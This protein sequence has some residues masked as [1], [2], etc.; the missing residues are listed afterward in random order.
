MVGL[1]GRFRRQPGGLHAAGPQADP[2]PDAPLAEASTTAAKQNLWLIRLAFGLAA[3][4]MAANIGL[5]AAVV[6][7]AREW[8]PFPVFVRMGG[9]D[10]KVIWFEPGNVAGDTREIV[11]EKLLLQFVEA[12]ETIDRQTEQ[13]RWKF[14]KYLMD[15]Q[16]A[17][18]FFR[19]MSFKTNPDSPYKK[20]EDAK[21][22]RA[23]SATRVSQLP[24]NV[25]QVEYTTI[26]Y[27]GDQPVLHKTWVATVT[28]TY[29]RTK[30]KFEDRFMNPFG[31]VVVRYSVAERMQ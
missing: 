15:Q 22:T 8:Q 1:I 4:S 9:S 25:F 14:V 30:V 23:A 5:S 10:D 28:V 7:L 20:L 16:L 13:E 17:D 3:A 11:S 19:F 26:D 2:K 6:E 29:R 21:Q 31:L 12:K 18:E 24:G 27:K